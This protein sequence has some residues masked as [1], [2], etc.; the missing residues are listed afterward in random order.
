MR[1]LSTCRRL[2]TTAFFFFVG[3]TFAASPGSPIESPEKPPAVEFSGASTRT[4]LRV[5]VYPD[6]A[7]PPETNYWVAVAQ[8]LTTGHLREVKQIH[9]YPLHLEP[10]IQDLIKPEEAINEMQ[11]QQLQKPMNDRAIWC[12]KLGRRRDAWS[13]TARFFTA[14]TNESCKPVTLA[15][16]DLQE[17]V[18]KLNEDVLQRLNI[19]L[20]HS[21]RIK[22]TRPWTDS[23]A[24][25]ECYARG[26]YSQAVK[27]DPSFVQA[28]DAIAVALSNIGKWE[29]AEAA[30][31][32]A[33]RLNSDDSRAHAVLGASMWVRGNV[34]DSENELQLA[35]RLDPDD[36]SAL[37]HL[38]WQYRAQNLQSK[39]INAYLLALK[40]DPHATTAIFMHAELGYLYAHQGNW[41]EALSELEIASQKSAMQDMQ[42]EQDLADGY[43]TLGKVP[44]F[45][46]HAERYLALAKQQGANQQQV[47]AFEKFLLEWKPRLTPVYIKSPR[48]KEFGP[49][50]LAKALGDNLSTEEMTLAINP[51]KTTPE[52][53]N[54]AQGLTAGA[55]NELEKARTLFDALVPR[56]KND[57]VLPSQFSQTAADVWKALQN[58]KTTLHCQDASFL[59]VAAARAVGLNAYAAQIDETCDGTKAQHMCSAIYIDGKAALVDPSYYWFGAPHKRFTVLD[60][61]QTIGV[62]LSSSADLKQNQVAAKL[63]PGIPLVR[64]NLCRTLMDLD[65]WDDVRTLLPA[66]QKIDTNAALTASVQGA[67]AVHDGDLEIATSHLRK[68]IEIDPHGFYAH[69][70]LGRIYAAQGKP[71]EARKSYQEALDCPHTEQDTEAINRAISKIAPK[72][73]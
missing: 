19:N 3:L 63:A 42:L 51:L 70:Q 44:Q 71:N 4:S 68:A 17:L 55:T 13:A 18:N 64:Y 36:N 58:P 8:E 23:P 11:A 66:L 67:L 41:K 1:R 21:E 31:R 39:A 20:S 52:I 6:D 12:V 46:K 43:A 27:L 50:S 29:Q 14:I 59:L 38:G 53:I 5:L 45:V 16:G 65:R 15:S 62:Y 69:A 40:A 9:V 61:V 10:A 22:L 47:R 33:L 48:P 60:D 2:L 72:G 24:A 26:D 32:E 35:A 7:D 54:W 25:L 49:A 34:S 73:S 37:T 28:Y 30:A 56:I 57:A